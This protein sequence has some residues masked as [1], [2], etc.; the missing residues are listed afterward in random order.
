VLALVLSAP[1]A[2]PALSPNQDAWQVQAQSQRSKLLARLGVDRWQA[3]GVRGQGVKIAVLDTGFRGYR[4]HLGHSLPT[5]V[6]ARSFRAD[7]NLEH[8]NSQH[9]ILCAEVIHAIAPDA[10]LLFANWDVEYPEQFLAAVRWAREHGAR[11]I[12]C[13]V[14]VPNWSDGE[15]K[16][17]VHEKLTRILGPGSAAGDELCFASAGN[18]TVRHWGGLFHDGGDG[19]HEWKPGQKDNGVTP[20]GKERCSVELYWQ[21]GADYDLT[22]YDADTGREVGVAHTDHNHGDRSSAVVYFQA[23]P[24]HGYRARV[25]LVRGQAGKFHLCTMESY[26][27]YTTAEGSVCFP[28]DGSR[29]IAMGAEDGRGHKVSYSACG[30]SA[31]RPKPDFVATIPFP[32][33]WRERPFAGTSAAAPQGSALAALLWSRHPNWTADQVRAAL[34]ASAEDLGPPGPDPETG[35]GLLHLPRE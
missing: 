35:Y 28:A 18:T 15:G 20:W 9:G 26:L 7:A 4:N 31:V 17:E 27:E 30:S 22:V 25:R 19:Y 6:L 8:R 23:E 12:S 11:I 14:V 21:P 13:S 33:L 1:A 32:S 29:V 5:T 3:A 16:G 24:G 34:K 2:P 10:E